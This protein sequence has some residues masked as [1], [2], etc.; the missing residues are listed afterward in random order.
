MQT[1]IG[2]KTYTNPIVKYA[3]MTKEEKDQIPTIQLENDVRKSNTFWGPNP[4]VAPATDLPALI[5]TY[6]LGKEAEATLERYGVL[7][8]VDAIADTFESKIDGRTNFVYSSS[9]PV[10][11][12]APKVVEINDK[13]EA[14]DDMYFDED[15]LPRLDD[16]DWAEYDDIFY[17]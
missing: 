10:A 17:D 6:L 9:I 13:T 12:A 16:D 14:I 1:N 3:H 2:K 7:R 5:Q 15:E 4:V 8:M 11:P